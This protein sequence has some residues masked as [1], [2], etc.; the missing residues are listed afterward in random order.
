MEHTIRRSNRARHVWLRI[1]RDGDL[2]VVVPVGYDA[3]RVP[4]LL[5]EKRLWIERASSRL[6]AQSAGWPADD[7]VALPR[8]IRFEATGEGWTVQ[9]RS[10]TNRRTAARVVS[11]G[12]LEVRG[13]VDQTDACREALR[14]WVVREARVRLESWLRQMAVESGFRVGRVSIRSQHTR[15][16]SCSRRG[17]ISLNTRLLF[18]T[19]ELVRHVLLHELCHTKHLNHSSKFWSLLERHDP[20]CARHRLELRAAWG[21]AP[22]WLYGQN[23]AGPSEA[24]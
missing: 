17:D 3:S 21:Q 10:S 13:E 11:D 14:R 6:R 15:W 23:G 9:H 8:T 2:V 16:A 1:S 5:E 24:D 7:R 18:V 4:S 12:V 19:P 22:S 20:D